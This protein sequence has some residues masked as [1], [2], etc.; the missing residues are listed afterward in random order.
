MNKVEL[1]LLSL[2]EMDIEDESIY[3]EREKRE[4]ERERDCLKDETPPTDLLQWN[5]FLF[6]PLSYAALSSL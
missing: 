5:F 2:M 1:L 4:R 3:N 6:F